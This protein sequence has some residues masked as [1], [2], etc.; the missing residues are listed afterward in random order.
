[1]S[2]E[3]NRR[4]EYLKKMLTARKLAQVGYPV[5]LRETPIDK[6]N[7]RR[8]TRLKNDE[9]HA[10]Y[11]YARRLDKGYS[12]QSPDGMTKPTIEHVQQYIRD[13][14]HKGI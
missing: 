4:L 12:D 1:M 3:I 14:S 5:F 13:I 11:P 10:D 2:G 8:K 7:A 9:I 6:G